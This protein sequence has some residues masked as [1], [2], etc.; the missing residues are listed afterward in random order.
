MIDIIKKI[1][2]Y[3][4]D[5]IM[6]EQFGKYS[7]YIIQDRAIPDVRDGLKPVQRRIL[8]AMYKNNNTFDK[9]TV[10]SALTVGDVIGKYH[11]H[12]DTS[13]YDAMVRMSQTWKQRCPYIVFQGNNGSQDGDPQAAY[14]YTEAKLSKISN[15]M[16][17]DINKDTVNFAPTFDDSRQEP[18]VMPARFPALLV[19][20]STGISAGYATNIP[21]HNLGEIIDAT[22]KRIESPNCTLEKLMTIIKG[23][24]FPTGGI[25]EGLKGIEEAY[26]TGKGKIIIRAKYE[27]QK[28]K[29]KDQIVI[30]EIP[31]EVTIT[32]IVKKIEEIRIDKK[33]DGIQEARNESGKEGLKIVVDLKAGADKNLILMYLLKNTDL[34][35]SYN[36]NMVA[37]VN[38]RPKQLGILP[39]LDA[40]ITHQKEVVTRRTQF[41]LAFAKKEFHI[42]EGL[43]KAL[44][45]LDEV[46]RVIR[47]SKNRADAENNLVKELDFTMEQSKAIVALQLYRLTNTDVDELLKRLE[48]LKKVIEFLT[49]IL[50]DE[51]VLEKVLKDELKAIKKEYDTPR[52]SEIVEEITEIKIDAT[53]MIQKENTIVSITNEGYIK[54]VNLKSYSAEEPTT[55]KPG[56]YQVFLT[57]LTTLD[58]LLLFTNQGRYIYLPVH[59]INDS[60]WKELGKHINSYVMLN[61][62]ES[63]VKTMVLEKEQL[64]TFATK[65][66]ATKQTLSNDFIVTRYSKP[67]TAIKL[68]EEDELIN[69]EI[70]TKQN[71]FVTKNG[72]YLLMNTNEIPIVGAKAAGVKGISLK[73][74]DEVVSYISVENTEDYLTVFTSKSTAKRIKFQ[75]LDKSSRT[76]KGSSLLKKIK[77]TKYD[78]IGALQL[79]NK[80]EV[81]IKSGTDII[82][83]KTTDISIMDL[84]STG[85]TISKYEIDKISLKS[86]LI[87]YEEIKNTIFKKEIEEN[88]EKNI[89]NDPK[90]NKKEIEQLTIDDFLEDFKV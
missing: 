13:V 2:E 7:K 28:N 18:T 32:N 88:I 26:Q 19:N 75:E 40:Y 81:T 70:S 10:K 47:A 59:E 42:T 27:F 85:S 77:T 66:G 48:T 15:E 8:Y 53:S 24:D 72:N 46:I 17:K 33:I 44:G 56:D 69:V 14:R 9:K 31:Y 74:D 62:E 21:P 45:I 35:V 90:S 89:E 20:G 78:I 37:I 83:I 49:T 39:I 82:E 50:N 16:I 1:R 73:D 64:L 41:D 43:V 57:Q 6:G 29:T 79:N 67:L 65:N 71:I 63:I 3:S 76:K 12:G 54:R 23:P 86:N 61:T 36:F 38:R 84:Q 87:K 68:K 51:K 5:E 60:K 11:P 25:V 52:R 58:T 55:M 22:I 80:D 34:Q 4:L 30:T